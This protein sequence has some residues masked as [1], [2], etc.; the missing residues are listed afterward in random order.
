MPWFHTLMPHRIVA[1]EMLTIIVP[2]KRRVKFRKGLFFSLGTAYLILRNSRKLKLK[3][4][5]KIKFNSGMIS[6]Q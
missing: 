6:K 2:V 5:R 4:V 1:R 3:K